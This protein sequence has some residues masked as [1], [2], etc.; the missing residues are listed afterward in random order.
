MLRYAFHIKNSYRRKN[1]ILRNP[2]VKVG[3]TRYGRAP[4]PL[5]RLEI[6][7]ESS[8]S[9]LFGNGFLCS[10]IPQFVDQCKLLP[11]EFALFAQLSKTKQMAFVFKKLTKV[12]ES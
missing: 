1:T 2:I 9:N 10:A 6:H 12:F 4:S 11:H 7:I 5:S 8:T 3:I